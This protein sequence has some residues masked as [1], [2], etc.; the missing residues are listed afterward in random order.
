MEFKTQEDYIASVGKD[1]TKHHSYMESVAQY[2]QTMNE[3]PSASKKVLGD[4]MRK[5]RTLK[6]EKKSASKTIA[7]KRMFITL[8]AYKDPENEYTQPPDP[9]HMCTRNLKGVAT[10]G[11]YVLAAGEREGH[12]HVEDYD[13]VGTRD[14]TLIDD[15]HCVLS[16]AQ[17]DKKK[18]ILNAG[19]TAEYGH[20]GGRLLNIM[21]LLRRHG[22]IGDAESSESAS[23]EGSD[24]Y[25]ESDDEDEDTSARMLVGSLASGVHQK[26]QQSA[27][28]KSKAQSAPTRKNSPSV[29]NGP[30]HGSVPPAAKKN[31]TEASPQARGRGRPSKSQIRGIAEISDRE[32]Q[33]CDDFKKALDVAQDLL[34]A[35]P[36]DSTHDLSKPAE[37]KEFKK[38]LQLNLGECAKVTKKLS[39]VDK[40]L[41]EAST[42]FDVT[43][44]LC[45]HKSYCDLNNA[46]M[47]ISS[48]ILSD[49][50]HV[51]KVEFA[52]SK[53]AESGLQLSF[54]FATKLFEMKTSR[55]IQFDDFDRFAKMFVHRSEDVRS[56][57]D[58]GLL[59]DN[60]EEFLLSVVE[61]TFAILV[62][63]V[64]SHDAAKNGKSKQRLLSYIRSMVTHCDLGGYDSD[65]VVADALKQ[66]EKIVDAENTAVGNL[67]D[68]VAKVE[69]VQPDDEDSSRMLVI[70]KTH[71]SGVME[72]AVM[73]VERRSVEIKGD[74][75]LKDFESALPRR[76][77]LPDTSSFLKGVETS[78]N[79][80]KEISALK[81][82]S[83]KQVAAFEV[84]KKALVILV[85]HAIST[86]RTS[87]LEEL[88]QGAHKLI[89]VCDGNHKMKVFLEEVLA[90]PDCSSVFGDSTTSS[91]SSL[92]NSILPRVTFCF[93][94][95]PARPKPPPLLSPHPLAALFTHPK[96]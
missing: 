41:K 48:L 84:L 22:A 92:S 1:A 33:V 60:M 35:V 6:L 36:F 81:K 7:P 27:S 13:E 38:R 40:R 66:A 8:A 46:A 93:V 2:I 79:I 10:E 49:H 64:T 37:L 73:N 57:A 96:L 86:L 53:L 34:M 45:K 76:M 82:K 94:A 77:E 28:S 20:K 65:D 70:L 9:K 54:P 43:S 16:P 25:S 12:Y 50:S 14:T 75:L 59:Q 85:S 71:G 30:R 90:K 69:K 17:I 42:R 4:K 24:S 19:I 62:R 88:I 61:G 47:T 68:A 55:H 44:L 52:F 3:D 58:S 18:E 63:A 32:Q 56:L 91:F 23:C 15:G 26:Q 31:N 11:I 5:E 74:S 72:V 89:G 83:K 29:L 51:D 67:R 87:L 39:D 80:V 95:R 78:L 21:D